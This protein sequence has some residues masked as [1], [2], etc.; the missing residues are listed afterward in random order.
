MGILYDEYYEKHLKSFLLLK[1]C[2]SAECRIIFKW[3]IMSEKCD[4]YAQLIQGKSLKWQ[5]YL[6]GFLM[7]MPI[8]ILFEH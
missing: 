7:L 8:F 3:K 2:K 6:C 4:K 5:Q 1:Y